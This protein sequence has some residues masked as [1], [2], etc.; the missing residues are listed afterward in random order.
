MAR[1]RAFSAGSSL[2]LDRGPK[3]THLLRLDPAK[4]SSRGSRRTGLVR[5]I[6][7]S[8]ERSKLTSV[9]AEYELL[10]HR[11]RISASA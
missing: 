8:S 11:L 4:N 2:S 3:T 6:T 10:G 5:V 1:A 9:V 7:I